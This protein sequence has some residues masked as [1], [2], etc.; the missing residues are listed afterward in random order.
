LYNISGNAVK[1][2]QFR[3]LPLYLRLNIYWLGRSVL[4]D[5][6]GQSPGS[7]R[8]GP[9]LIYG[10]SVWDMWWTME[11]NFLRARGVTLWEM[12]HQCSKVVNANIT[13]AMCSE[14]DQFWS[15]TKLL[16][17]EFKGLFSGQSRPGMMLNTHLHIVLR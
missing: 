10:K 5:L 15:A 4:D 12:L 11:Q 13:E 1:R 3:H 17:S 6:W 2:N 9:G 14:Q 8:R 7:H 16:F